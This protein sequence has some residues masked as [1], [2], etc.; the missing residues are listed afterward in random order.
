M[1]GLPCA[2]PEC[3]VLV[4]REAHACGCSWPETREDETRHRWLWAAETPVG[5]GGRALTGA[6]EGRVRLAAGLGLAT[7]QMIH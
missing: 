5:C 2:S 3:C 1:E 6:P 7:A 4:S